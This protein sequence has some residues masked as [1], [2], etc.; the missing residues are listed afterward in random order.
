MDQNLNLSEVGVQ[1]NV[2]V[3]PDQ[4]DKLRYLAYKDK[5]NV[6]EIV[7]NLIEQVPDKR[8]EPKE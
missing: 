1:V 7:R 3:Y 6:A 4:F 5:T 8:P 2:L